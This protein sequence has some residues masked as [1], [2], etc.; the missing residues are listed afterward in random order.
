V[1]DYQNIHLTAHELFAEPG[2]QKHMSLIDP[3][4][5]AVQLVA[6]RNAGQR[7]GYTPA[8]LERVR[9][10]RGL[11][12]EE[13]DPQPYR[14]NLAQRAQWTRDRRV[15]VHL[16]PL[17][18]RYER[19]ATGRPLLDVRGRKTIT[20]VREKGVDVLVALALVR[21]SIDPDVGL[22]ILASHD[23]DLA[24]ALDEALDVGKAKVETCCWWNPDRHRTG[25]PQPSGDRRVWNTRLRRAEFDRCQ[26]RTDYS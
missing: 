7:A 12:S 24:P 19:D 15:Q 23:T 25:A 13:H 8:V 11:P 3:L 1:I 18:Y 21:E 10:F 16:R 20:E 26:D 22:V 14:R 9:V 17:T 5:F 6:A 4:Q 2:A